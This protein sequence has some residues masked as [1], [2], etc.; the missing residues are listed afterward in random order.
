[1]IIKLSPDP[2]TYL[3]AGFYFI[4]KSIFFKKLL[5]RLTHHDN[6]TA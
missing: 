2:D 5:K 3:G 4:G 1:M 6:I